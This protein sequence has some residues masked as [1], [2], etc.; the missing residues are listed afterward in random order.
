ME[1]ATDPG[2]DHALSLLGWSGSFRDPDS[3]MGPLLGSSQARLGC[4]DA[5]L[6][7]AVNRAAAM[8]QGDP[9]TASYK[10]LNDRVSEVVP[11]VPLSHPVSA[12]AVNSRVVNFPLT[13]TGFERFNEIQL[14]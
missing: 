10:A 12:V 5:G 6:S 8:A 9:R 4:D 14:A 11:A 1:T 3:F 13:S 2:A 7:T